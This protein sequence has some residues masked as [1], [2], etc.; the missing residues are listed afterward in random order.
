MATITTERKKELTQAGFFVENMQRANGPGWWN[1]LWRF[2]D[3][4]CD[5]IGSPQS[6]EEAAWADLDQYH[7]QLQAR[8]EA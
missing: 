7:R 3:H 2:L 1:G 5:H 8:G 6:S 4:A